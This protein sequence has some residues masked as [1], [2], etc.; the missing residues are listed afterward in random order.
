MKLRN[1][2]FLV[3]LYEMQMCSAAHI[4]PEINAIINSL[5]LILDSDLER[6]KKVETYNH[7]LFPN[8][9]R[10]VGVHTFTD[11]RS[12]NHVRKRNCSSLPPAGVDPEQSLN[13]GQRSRSQDAARGSPPIAAMEL[14]GKTPPRILMGSPCSQSRG[15]QLA[16]GPHAAARVP[17]PRTIMYCSSSVRMGQGRNKNQIKLCIR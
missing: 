11:W 12:L 5:F 13:S 7:N 2:V 8:H 16:L 10:C 3:A 6:K 17:G 1:E 9:T 15:A 4:R 14:E